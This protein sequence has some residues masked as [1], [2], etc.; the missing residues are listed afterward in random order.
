GAAFGLGFMFGPLIGGLLANYS[1]M[2]AGFG[3]AG[4]SFMAFLFAFFLLPETITEKKSLI[5]FQ[6]KILDI[7]YVKSTLR[8]PAVGLLII[9]FFIIV[10]S[11]ANIYGTFSIL[12]YR[13]YNFTDQENGYLFGIIGIVSTL[14]QGGFIRMLSEKFED[15]NLVLSGSIFMMFGLG[16]LP[17]GINFWGVA[18]VVSVL[19]I[20]TGILQPTILSMIS[21]YSPEK[22][23]GGILGLN[24]SFSAFARVLGPLWGGFAFDVIGYQYPFLTG[25][26]F[27]FITFLIGF[28]L[29]NTKRLQ[30]N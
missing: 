25:A 11:M 10:F 18:L 8:H 29:L 5:N 2:V 17:Y 21:K 4:F 22:E 7:E 1:Y 14:M 16:F 20:G 12:G 30:E 9:L 19:S 13:V 23:Q 6:Y 27:T 3:S 24:Q 15:R 26:V 28:F